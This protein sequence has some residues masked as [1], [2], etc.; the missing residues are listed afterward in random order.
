MVYNLIFIEGESQENHNLYKDHYSTMV[1]TAKKVAKKCTTVTKMVKNIN[2]LVETIQIDIPENCKQVFI[3]IL[4]TEYLN[5]NIN[6]ILKSIEDVPFRF[7]YTALLF[8]DCF[9]DYL[10]KSWIDSGLYYCKIIF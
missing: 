1:T 10:K 7:V 9:N 4:I 6:L 8:T 3:C 5:F 2:R